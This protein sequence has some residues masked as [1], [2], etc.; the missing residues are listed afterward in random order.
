MSN[1]LFT[2]E[3]SNRNKDQAKGVA[4][5]VPGKARGKVDKLV[6]SKREEI[7]GPS[8]QI[9][10]KVRKGVGD[11]KQYGAAKT[12]SAFSG[13]KNTKKRIDRKNNYP[14]QKEEFERLLKDAL[15]AKY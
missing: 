15:Q 6:G 5:K 7:K 10:G 4:K 8:K 11:G 14:S 1:I 2:T 12:R 9:S 13:K 3:Q